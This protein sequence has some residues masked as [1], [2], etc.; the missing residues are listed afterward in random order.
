MVTLNMV[1]LSINHLC[2]VPHCYQTI[3]GSYKLLVGT[4]WA[5]PIWHSVKKSSYKYLQAFLSMHSSVPW[6]TKV[7]KL[8]TAAQSKPMILPNVDPST[9]EN[10]P[11]MSATSNTNGTSNQQNLQ[12]NNNLRWVKPHIFVLCPFRNYYPIL[13]QLGTLYYCCNFFKSM[14][15]MRCQCFRGNYLFL[16]YVS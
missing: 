7:N 8:I 14:L 2:P 12:Q 15:C 4:Y 11:N 5:A 9:N 16:Q 1:A 3:S 13:F 10:Q 6:Q